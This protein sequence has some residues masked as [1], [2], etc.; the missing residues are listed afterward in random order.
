MLLGVFLHLFHHRLSL[1]AVTRLLVVSVYNRAR[2]AKVIISD[3]L[4]SPIPVVQ[5]TWSATYHCSWTQFR[6]ISLLAWVILHLWWR[7][8]AARSFSSRLDPHHAPS[9]Y[10]MYSTARRYQIISS[11]LAVSLT[12]GIQSSLHGLP[13]RFQTL[14]DVSRLLVGGMIQRDR[15]GRQ[16]SVFQQPRNTID[17]WHP[18]RPG[19]SQIMRHP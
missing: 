7:L 3:L 17:L 12:L 2:L 4:I 18:D 1:R 13:S 16:I 10:A 14:N 11:V 6:A 5:N 9:C 8:I 15:C 19:R